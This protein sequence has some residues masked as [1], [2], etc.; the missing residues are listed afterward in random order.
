MTQRMPPEVIKPYPKVTHESNEV[1]IGN[2][3]SPNW[4]ISTNKNLVSQVNIIIN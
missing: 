2:K 3:T 1:T 4:N